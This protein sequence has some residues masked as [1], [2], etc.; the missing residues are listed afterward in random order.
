MADISYKVLDV[1]GNHLVVKYK[2][3]DD[4]VILQMALVLPFTS[5][6]DLINKRCPFP[7]EP[8]RTRDFSAQIGKSGVVDRVAA[9]KLPASPSPVPTQTSPPEQDGD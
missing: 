4:V 1:E 5:I 6:E 2:R 9:M 8:D 3:G 7:P